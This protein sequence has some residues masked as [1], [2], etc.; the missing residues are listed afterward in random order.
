MSVRGE[1]NVSKQWNKITS[2]FVVWKYW[3]I[4]HVW[5]IEYTQEDFLSL[6]I[7]YRECDECISRTWDTFDTRFQEKQKITPNNIKK[8]CPITFFLIGWGMQ[9]VP[10]SEMNINLY[11]YYYYYICENYFSEWNEV[12]EILFIYFLCWHS[13]IYLIVTSK[14]ILLLRF[15]HS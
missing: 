4:N 7:I 13:K 8:F 10:Q 14:I 12:G 6:L 15:V 11:L 3:I 2:Q 5:T 9:K 1:N